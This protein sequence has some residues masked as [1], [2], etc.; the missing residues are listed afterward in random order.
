MLND[1]DGEMVASLEQDNK[2]RLTPKKWDFCFFFFFG[3]TRV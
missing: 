3:G 2:D 1:G